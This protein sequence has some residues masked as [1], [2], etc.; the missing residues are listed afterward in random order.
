MACSGSRCIMACSAPLH[1][2]GG[3]PLIST[4]PSGGLFGAQQ[5]ATASTAAAAGFSFGLSAA[6]DVALEFRH[7]Y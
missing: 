7:A 2:G 1:A 5:G 3:F 4:A 6:G